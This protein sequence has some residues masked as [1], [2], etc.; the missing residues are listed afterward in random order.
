MSAYQTL[1][2]RINSSAIF[3]ISDSYQATSRTIDEMET[4]THFNTPIG[5][6]SDRV[7]ICVMNIFPAKSAGFSMLYRVYRSHRI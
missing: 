7:V 5:I 2:K 4:E 1:P 6:T 3:R